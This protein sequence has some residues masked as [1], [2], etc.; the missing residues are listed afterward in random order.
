MN[1]KYNASKGNKR[2]KN[3]EKS[4]NLKKQKPLEGT[5]LK[6]ELRQAD[7]AGQQNRRA[8][9]KNTRIDTAMREG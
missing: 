7:E 5:V 1:G 4:R 8:G 6:N 2:A 9:G 3:Q